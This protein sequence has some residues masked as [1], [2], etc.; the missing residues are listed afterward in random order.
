MV[1]YSSRCVAE[2]VPLLTEIWSRHLSNLA[3]KTLPLLKWPG[4]K[5]A[6]LDSIEKVLPS[7]FGCYYEPFVGGG[8][9]FFALS[10]GCAVLADKN[11][12]LIECYE[13]VRDDPDDVI[14][15][16][17]AMGNSEGDYYRIR[18]LQPETAI[19]RAARL[20]YLTILS[21]NGIYRVNL[22]GQF[23]VP[24]GYRTHLDPCDVTRIRSAS[25]VLAEAKLLR[26]DFEKAVETAKHG[27]LVYLDPP[28]T[29]AHAKNGFLK[30]NARIFSWDDQTRL[31]RVAHTLAARGCH[32][33]VSNAD[34]ESLRDLY[35]GFEVLEVVRPSRIAASSDYRRRVTECLFYKECP[36]ADEY[37][38]H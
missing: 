5:R 38:P 19:G 30:Y 37:P 33:I 21:F 17:R 36:H 12:E 7:E 10:P 8:A 26:A 32:V 28:Y 20:I 15:E 29:V 16:L 1:I 9:L 31:A 22:K 14:A 4:G 27:D 18:A 13:V 24:Y 11:S 34:H 6:I 2:S 3:R 35:D 23:N 25:K